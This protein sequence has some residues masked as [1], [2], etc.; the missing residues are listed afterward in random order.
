VFATI[1]PVE[2]FLERH[3]GLANLLTRRDRR[4]TDSPMGRIPANLAGH[5]VVVG[6]GRV[7]SII[8]RALAGQGVPFVVVERN[9]RVYSRDLEHSSMQAVAGDASAPGVLLAA[10]ISTASLLVIASPDGYYARRV[11]EIARSVNPG[12]RTIVRTHSTEEREYL[13]GQGV[14]HVVMAEHELAAAMSSYTLQCFGLQA[15]RSL[16][17]ANTLRPD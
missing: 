3:P 4:A 14:T 10:R 1:A 7:G 9:Q 2:L 13:L 8:A 15:D 12:I 17:V 6:H 16:Q 5:A 11:L